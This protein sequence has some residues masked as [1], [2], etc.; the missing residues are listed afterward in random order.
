MHRVLGSA[1]LLVAAI[2]LGLSCGD[3]DSPTAPPM[4]IEDHTIRR[5]G[6]FHRAGL[7]DPEQN[8]VQC[9]GA[10]LQGGDN[11]EPSCFLCHGAVWN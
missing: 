7:N 3:S 4:G 10:D 2:V 9:H 11:G 1:T 5:G 6:A 8:C